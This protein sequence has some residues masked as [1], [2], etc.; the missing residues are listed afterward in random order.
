MEREAHTHTHHAE[1]STSATSSVERRGPTSPA[2]DSDNSTDVSEA[3][4]QLPSTAETTVDRGSGKRMTVTLLKP[5]DGK[6]RL[7]AW[8]W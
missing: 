2:P 4:L 5:S 7:M 6:T 3:A 8:C 1:G